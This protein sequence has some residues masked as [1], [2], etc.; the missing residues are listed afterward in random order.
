[1]RYLNKEHDQDV[2]DDVRC[3]VV[4]RAHR[5][6]LAA[7][8]EGL[9]ERPGSERLREETRGLVLPVVRVD[10]VDQYGGWAEVFS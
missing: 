4:S 5:V 1:M 6:S 7:L 8:G 10:P 2:G 9:R 3:A